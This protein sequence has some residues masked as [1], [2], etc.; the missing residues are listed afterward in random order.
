MNY[1]T[2]ANQLGLL[3]ILVSSAL[4]VMSGVF[5]STELLS[6]RQVDNNAVA[7]L[8]VTGLGGILIS[9]ATWYFSRRGSRFLGRK[10]A[11]LLVA[12][13]WVGGALLGAMPFWIW[14]NLH[15]DAG[16]S[17]PFQSLINCYFESM[18]GLTTTGA[19]VL[20][21]M[22]T[23]PHSLLLWRALTHWLGGLGIVVLF[24]AVLPGLGVGGKRLF[25]IESPG[26]APQGLQPRIRET[27][28]WLWFIYLGLTLLEIA[29]LWIF[30]PMDGFHSV[31]HTFAT[32]ATGG[33]STMNASVGAFHRTPAVDII[34]TT[35]MVLAGINFALYYRLC[36][37]RLDSLFKDTE[38][39]VY[40]S[41]LVV[42]ILIVS[43]TVAF[44]AEP[45]YLTDGTVVNA[46]IG[47][48]LRQS[49]FT[50]VSIQ[51][52]TGF[53]TSDFNRWP[54]LAKAVLVLLMFIGGSSGSTAGGIK[55]IRVWVA[56]RVLLAEIEHVF[57]PHVVR[58]L[59]VGQSV[60]DSEMR[61]GAVAYVLGMIILFGVGSGLIMLIEQVNSTSECDFTTAATAC[62]AT[63]FNVGPGLGKVG[64]VEHYG[65]FS[66]ATKCV[67]CVL[68]A[69]GRLEV[70]AIIVL[71]SP[72]F[73]H[74]D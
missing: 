35:F 44:S 38:L 59:R 55:I 36:R 50:T 9:G 37:G 48:T 25:Q 29:A 11:L 62:A 10:E 42:G 26:P 39:R 17:H 8:F 53:C 71:F 69:L 13:S 74:R 6:S 49:T 24:V 16:Q 14:A 65:W 20:T 43:A 21:S 32:L 23:M 63:L 68:M 34:I 2:V 3:G 45:I 47:Q 60:V 66:Q 15:F 40:V 28:R 30:T 31:C 7:A 58:P 73:W 4:L 51:T 72:R 33:F 27:A 52:T 70:F 41:L 56:A 19:T 54:F 67:M 5:L 61:L 22:E 18:S 12:A 57:R 64:A 1:R 46:T